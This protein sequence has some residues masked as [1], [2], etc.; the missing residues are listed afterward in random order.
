MEKWKPW[1][2]SVKGGNMCFHRFC[3][4]ENAAFELSGVY[5]LPNPI[6][7]KKFDEQVIDSAFK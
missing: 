1:V 7:L 3:V 2:I 6:G 4:E 5:F